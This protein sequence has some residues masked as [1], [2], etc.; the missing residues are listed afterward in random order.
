MR[1][2]GTCNDAL[3]A[4]FPP[5]LSNTLLFTVVMRGATTL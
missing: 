5:G 4:A 3:Q 1:K 2:S